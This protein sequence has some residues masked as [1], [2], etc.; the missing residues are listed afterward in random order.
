[1]FG[2][3]QADIPFGRRLLVLLLVVIAVSVLEPSLAPAF[4]SD[5]LQFATDV[6]LLFGAATIVS[7]VPVLIV[8][9][10]YMLLFA[11]LF[12]ALRKTSEQSAFWSYARTRKRPVSQRLFVEGM[13]LLAIPVILAFIGN[14]LFRS[15]GFA[16]LCLSIL[17]VMFSTESEPDE[18]DVIHLEF[19][20]RW[21][22]VVLFR[23]GFFRRQVLLEDL[24]G[25]PNQAK[26]E[27]LAHGWQPLDFPDGGRDQL[28]LSKPSNPTAYM[29]LVYWDMAELVR[30]LPKRIRR[31][32]R[33]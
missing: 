1:M 6:M 3:F 21:T 26:A 2:F 28:W 30:H 33:R 27:L 31:S 15:V 4:S 8:Y 14:P 29:R 23:N 13:F 22:V 12:L 11:P 16:G 18:L 10:A 19:G 32:S 7:M 5:P 9:L 25:F 17:F 24:G 20:E